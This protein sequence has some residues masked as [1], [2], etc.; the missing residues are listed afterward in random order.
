M[1]Y[2]KAAA[3]LHRGIGALGQTVPLVVGRASD[4]VVPAMKTSPAESVAIEE[5]ESLGL[6]PGNW[7]IWTL[8]EESSV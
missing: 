5:T 7:L 6:P 8:P 2:P 3:L 4:E 1:I